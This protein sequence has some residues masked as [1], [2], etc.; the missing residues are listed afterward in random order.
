VTGPANIP[1][2]KDADFEVDVLRYVWRA[3]RAAQ[4]G[5]PELE[6][7]TILSVALS[8]SGGRPVVRVEWSDP[9]EDGNPVHLL[10][11]VIPSEGPL[12]PGDIGDEIVW[13]LWAAAHGTS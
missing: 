11:H 1:D 12:R 10:C 7:V 9:R 3:W 13:D 2:R 8:D 5:N 6:G 4:H